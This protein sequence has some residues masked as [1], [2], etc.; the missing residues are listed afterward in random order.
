MPTGRGDTSANIQL[1]TRNLMAR[2]RTFRAL[3]YFTDFIA[4]TMDSLVLMIEVAAMIMSFSKYLD[5]CEF[6]ILT[7]TN[8]FNAVRRC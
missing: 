7:R 1:I 8:K 3:K 5:G 6:C 4:V 2:T